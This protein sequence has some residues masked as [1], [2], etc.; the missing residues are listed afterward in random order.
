MPENPLVRVPGAPLVFRQVNALR[1]QAVGRLRSFDLIRWPEVPYGER[2]GQQVNLWELNDLAPRD[3]WPAVL[4]LHGGGWRHGSPD[5]FTAFAPMLA[6]RGLMV[7]A[8]RYRLAPDHA[9][10]APLDDVLAAI[11]FM[12]GQQI[13]PTRLALWGHSAGGQLAMMAGL[14]RPEHVR[15]VV[16][17]GAPTDLAWTEE[18]ELFP[19]P[20]DASPLHRPEVPPP[21][22]MVHGTLDRVVPVQQARDYATRHPE[23]VSVMEVTDGDHGLRW[24]PAGARRARRQAIDWMMEQLSPASRGSKWKRK[25]KKKIDRGRAG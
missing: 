13:D 10:P 8:V 17:L 12:R 15:C 11:D 14:L 3:G 23:R 24:P 18:A 4:L 20:A 19:D 7:G 25:K 2:P 5:D 16:A 6:R 9:W 21:T 22:L 1:R